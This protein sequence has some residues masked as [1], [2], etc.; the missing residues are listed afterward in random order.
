MR[1]VAII[2]VGMTKWGELWEKSLRTIFVE[3]ALLA[4]DD[5]GVDKIDSMYV[6]SMSSGL[7]VGQEHIASLLADYL[8]QVPV[9]SARIETACAYGGLALRLGF[10]EVASGMSDVVLVSGIEKM[11]D[12]NGYEATYALGT[13]ADQEYEG[14]HGITFPGLYALIARAHMEKY[15]TRREQLALVAVKNHSNGSKN[16]LAQFPFEITVDSVLNS[17]MVADPLRVLDCSPITDGAAAV[18][19]CP[20]EMARKM[21]KPVVKI[22]GSGHATDF[23]SLSS[24]NDITWLEATYQAGK[25]AYAMAD[26]KPEDIDILEVHDCFTIAEIC[27][28][29]ALGIVEK[30]KGGEAVEDEITYL[31]GKI[32]VNT[33][34]GL[35]AKGHPVGATGV[36]QVMEIV[37]QLRGEA[38]KRQ[39]KDCR[40]GMAQNMGGSGGSAVV[41]IFERE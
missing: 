19:L 31:D 7:F 21:K 41:H 26:K 30:G 37:K 33:S 13:A 20:V 17:V 2:G 29:E 35:K 9:P 15:G 3:T 24:R 14:Y 34:G 39:I 32:P 27:V 4:M 22:T 25:R 18:I 1:D 10:M 38:D 40:I 23:I 8:G 5:A 36:A 16:P 12:V 6:G 28:L 11:T